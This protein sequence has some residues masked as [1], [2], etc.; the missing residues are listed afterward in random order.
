MRKLQ[1]KVQDL[2]IENKRVKLRIQHLEE[3][4]YPMKA[5]IPKIQ[6][7][8]SPEFSS[9]NSSLYRA[10]KAPKAEISVHNVS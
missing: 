1:E 8:P 9:D 2:V 5:A 6:G 10:P 3:M 7:E 4:C